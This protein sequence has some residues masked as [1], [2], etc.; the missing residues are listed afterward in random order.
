VDAPLS[1]LGNV[2]S[3]TL[4]ALLGN[5]P[6]AVADV[7]GLLANPASVVN[8]LPAADLAYLLDSLPVQIPG[9]LL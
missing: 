1:L 2:P 3:S 5:L 4:G 8:S 6:I 7:A 9:S